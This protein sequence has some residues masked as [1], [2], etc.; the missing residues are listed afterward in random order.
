[1][2]ANDFQDF[3]PRRRATFDP[4]PCPPKRR[5]H[6]VTPPPRHTEYD[7]GLLTLAVV[8]GCFAVIAII[9]GGF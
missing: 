2:S 5:L 7:R 3:G 4:A 8:L 1:M 6:I 9:L